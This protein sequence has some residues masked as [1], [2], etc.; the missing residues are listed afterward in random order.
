[1]ASVHAAGRH[2]LTTLS[3]RN[4]GTTWHSHPGPADPAE[5][6]RY[7]EGISDAQF[8]SKNAGHL[9]TRF[10]SRWAHRDLWV[11]RSPIQEAF[12]HGT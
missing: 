10:M 11:V 1:M 5:T 2:W 12:F 7:S 6:A 9:P 4:A 3:G 8:P